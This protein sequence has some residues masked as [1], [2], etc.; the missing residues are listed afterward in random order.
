MKLY[1]TRVPMSQRK[2]AQVGKRLVRGKSGGKQKFDTLGKV[3]K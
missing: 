3:G 1:L 2:L